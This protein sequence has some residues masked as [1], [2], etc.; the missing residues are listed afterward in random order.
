MRRRPSKAVATVLP[1]LPAIPE[2]QKMQAELARERALKAE[3]MRRLRD[4]NETL[5]Q[6][7]L[8]RAVVLAKMAA[9]RRGPLV[10]FFE[11]VGRKYRKLADE[12]PIVEGG[13][14]G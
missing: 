2:P 13:V 4:I 14:V 6:Q 12:G 10:D 3:I 11:E 1:A 5:T 9:H 7:D 8:D